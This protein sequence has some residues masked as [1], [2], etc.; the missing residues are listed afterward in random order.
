M[1]T[2]TLISLFLLLG[3]FTSSQVLGYPLITESA[4]KDLTGTS[5]SVAAVIIM[6]LPMF[7]GPLAGK[8]MDML[9]TTVNGVQTFPTESFQTAFL[10]FPIGFFIAFSLLSIVKEKA[11][12][13]VA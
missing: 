8:I 6:G 5:M 13:T 4:E 3:F 12:V 9:S 11:T 1:S 2:L 10:I 7:L